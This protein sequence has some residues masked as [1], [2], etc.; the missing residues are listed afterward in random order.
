MLETIS[1]YIVSKIE[2]DDVIVPDMREAYTYGMQTIVINFFGINLC[3]LI[4]L[5]MS[6]LITTFFFLIS[7]IITRRFT[8]GYHSHTFSQCMLKTSCILCIILLLCKQILLPFYVCVIILFICTL[9]FLICVPVENNNKKLSNKL[10]Q[11]CKKVSVFILIIQGII[12]L[13]LKGHG[14][15]L[16][17]IIFYSILVVSLLILFAV[18]RQRLTI[19]SQV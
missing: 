14:I 18:Y 11:R 9:V 12:G 6:E 1:N 15:D 3:L 2:K 13:I 4:G 16:Y 7:F 19:K 10:K 17:N 5:I 8:G